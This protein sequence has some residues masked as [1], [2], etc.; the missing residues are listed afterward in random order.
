[1]NKKPVHFL[2]LAF[3]LLLSF[4]VQISSAQPIVLGRDFSAIDR[5]ALSIGPVKSLDRLVSALKGVASDD[6]GKARAIYR[7]M[8]ANIA[9]DDDAY[10]GNVQAS[11]FEPA[12]VL[13]RGKAVCSGFSE[14]F[15][16]LAR[17]L[18]LKVVTISGRAKGYSYNSGDPE[19]P[20]NHDWNAVLVDGKWRLIDV[21]WAAG[22]ISESKGFQPDYTDFWFDTPPELFVL[23]HLPEVPAWQQL[24][25]KV[26]YAEYLAQP[27]YNHHDFEKL[28]NMGIAGETLLAWY[29]TG[30]VPEAS[31][32]QAYTDYGLDLQ[33]VLTAMSQGELPEC[34]YFAGLGLRILQAPLS[35][36]IP[37]GKLFSVAI[38]STGI[39]EAAIINN[40][41][42]TRL[43]P[44]G[45]RL[46]ADLIPEAGR[47]FV[48]IHT[49]VDG[50]KAWWRLLE[51]EV[52]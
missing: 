44:Q 21:T 22:S 25:R 40:G 16:Y 29:K 43:K 15:R 10:F 7:W 32:V 49:T 1:M 11:A 41:E 39:T 9:Y 18:D 48:S 52:R 5:A 45:L 33:V 47:L 23:W 4:P 17:A 14:L 34:Y 8:A 28:A 19:V 38:E 20:V 31:T 2:F 24:D 30:K 36:I 13:R 50:E 12:D 42:W 26:S 35:K 46:A 3:C 6:L 27:W 51:Y 37:K